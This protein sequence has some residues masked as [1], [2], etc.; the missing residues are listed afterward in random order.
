MNQGQQQQRQ[1]ELLLK[2]QKIQSELTGLMHQIDP[3]GSPPPVVNSAQH[4][5][6][7]FD[8]ID[9]SIA[10]RFRLSNEFMLNEFE[11]QVVAI[12]I[13]TM[14]C[15]C[16]AFYVLYK[17]IERYF[18]LNRRATSFLNQSEWMRVVAAS[19]LL[20]A[21]ARQSTQASNAPS[22]SAAAEAAESAST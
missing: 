18:I 14:V 15:I 13:I 2:M 7:T 12:G 5:T 20:L 16:S 22:T 3:K 10:N 17:V 1:K 4:I 19:D 6:E 11:Q 8:R 21:S 9:N